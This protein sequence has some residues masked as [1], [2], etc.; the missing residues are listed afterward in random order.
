MTDVSAEDRS[1]APSRSQTLKSADK[2][3]RPIRVMTA[4][5]AMRFSSSRL[6]EKEVQTGTSCAPRATWN[7]II[8]L[9]CWFSTLS[10]N[11]RLSLYRPFLQ[12]RALR[13]PAATPENRAKT[14]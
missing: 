12:V 10:P 2:T 6:R 4:I 5:F 7:E 1:W 13:A 11:H 3:D 14:W 9:R 8:G